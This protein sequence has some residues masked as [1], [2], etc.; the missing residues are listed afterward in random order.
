MPTSGEAARMISF[1]RTDVS[2]WM[3]HLRPGRRESEQGGSC[4]GAPSTDGRS[5]HEAP[6]AVTLIRQA[7]SSKRITPASNRSVSRLPMSSGS[8]HS[9]RPRISRSPPSSPMELS[10]AS[11]RPARGA[12]V[13]HEARRPNP[14]QHTT[15]HMPDRPVRR[16]RRVMEPTLLLPETTKRA[17]TLVHSRDFWP[18]R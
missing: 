15:P 3:V 12:A 11:T 1:V 5:T 4:L 18:I 10:I 9:P 6:A 7:S 8:I 2:A 14:Q 16:R 17:Q 13:N